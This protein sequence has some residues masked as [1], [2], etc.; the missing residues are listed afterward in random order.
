MVLNFVGIVFLCMT[1]HD[2]YDGIKANIFSEEIYI[3]IKQPDVCKATLG[4]RCIKKSPFSLRCHA[5][6]TIFDARN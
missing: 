6:K 4:A 3:H 2:I 5:D 1:N